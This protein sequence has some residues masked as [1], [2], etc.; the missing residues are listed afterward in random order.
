VDPLGRVR[1]WRVDRLTDRRARRPHGRRA[2]QIYGAEDAHAF[3]WEPVLQALALEVSDRLLDIGCGGGVFLRR[4]LESGCTGVG[5]D[6]SGDMVRLARKTVGP[7]AQIVHGKAEAL[8]FADAEFTAISCLAAFF[9]FPEPVAALRE[10]R[11]VL[12][13]ERGRIAIMTT[14]PEA[15]GTPAAPYPIASRGHYYDDLALRQLALDAGFATAD[16]TRW[17]EVGQ[18]LVARP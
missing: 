7:A 16:V 17:L 4:A 2:R 6:H 8:P 9:F 10:M 5:I 13:V 18:L 15:K 1:G 14:A 12:D 11:R 3:L